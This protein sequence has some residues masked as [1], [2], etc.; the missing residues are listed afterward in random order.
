MRGRNERS[1]LSNRSPNKII[2]TFH[3]SFPCKGSL[4]CAVLKATEIIMK[5][6]EKRGGT[7]GHEL[8]PTLLDLIGKKEDEKQVET[9]KEKRGE[10]EIREV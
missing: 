3:L 1:P 7:S 4:E 10:G 2:L 9:K 6:R 8:G 5:E